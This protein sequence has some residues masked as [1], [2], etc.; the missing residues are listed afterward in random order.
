MYFF[1]GS[2]LYLSENWDLAER[3]WVKLMKDF[4]R[5]KHGGNVMFDIS[6]IP[7]IYDSV[8]YDLE[9]NSREIN[10]MEIENLY[11]CSKYM[12]GYVCSKV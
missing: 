2:L 3:R 11:I 6:K 5:I 4:K 7:D 8:K 12:V 10:F 9:H 1:T